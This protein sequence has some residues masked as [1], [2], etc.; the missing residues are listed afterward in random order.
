MTGMHT[1]IRLIRRGQ[2]GRICEHEHM[3]GILLFGRF[4]E[5][6]RAYNDRPRVDHYHFAVSNHVLRIN[7]RLDAKVVQKRGGTVFIGLVGFVEDCE[8]L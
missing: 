2:I 4:G 1:D 6:E 7:A 5:V 3:L 8:D